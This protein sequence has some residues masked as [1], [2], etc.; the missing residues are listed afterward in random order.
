[1]DTVFPTG[2]I[3]NS[4]NSVETFPA[5][6]SIPRL[7]RDCIITEK[8]DGTNALIEIGEDA[9]GPTI[10]AGSRSRWIAPGKSTD[11]FGFAQW[12]Q[13]HR[14]DL[15]TLG[16]GLH[17][18]E[19]WGKGIQRGYGLDEKRFSLFHTAGIQS[20]PDCISVA[21]V[22]YDGPFDSHHIHNVLTD[23]AMHGS[24]AAPGFMKPEGIVIYHIASR[25]L[26]KQTLD[27]DGH[28]GAK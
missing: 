28:K 20:L 25:Q 23:L 17:Y 6:R 9:L 7:R 4:T 26:F 8:I 10:R 15:Y 16:P 13:D 24:K 22:L 3:G 19:W 12:V 11:N 14:L 2:S 18:G 21:P 27:G 5:Y 1:V